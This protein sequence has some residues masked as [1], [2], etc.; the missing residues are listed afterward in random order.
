MSAKGCSS[1]GRVL[2]S[3]TMGRGFESFRPCQIRNSKLIQ[4][5]RFAVFFLSLK[6]SRKS[7]IYK[8]FFAFVVHFGVGDINIPCLG[9][10]KI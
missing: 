9:N 10:L 6:I 5:C 2:V 7:L 8:G 3:K 4:K 1:V